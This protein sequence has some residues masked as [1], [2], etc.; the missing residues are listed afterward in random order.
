ML[1][2]GSTGRLERLR[3]GQLTYGGRW[4]DGRSGEVAG[5]V[6]PLCLRE[7]L[8][9]ARHREPPYVIIDLEGGR[10][11]SVA[12]YAAYDSAAVGVAAVRAA[13]PAGPPRPVEPYPG[14]AGFGPLWGLGVSSAGPLGGSSPAGPPPST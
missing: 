11:S 8:R 6:F 1:A 2:A 4:P 7:P 12:G 3:R 13:A 14:V 9:P 5:R 10:L